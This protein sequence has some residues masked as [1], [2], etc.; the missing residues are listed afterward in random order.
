LWEK[1]GGFDCELPGT[2][3]IRELGE[4]IFKSKRMSRKLETDLCK[5][6]TKTN[7]EKFENFLAQERHYNNWRC[8]FAFKKKKR[9]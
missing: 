4:D 1:I 6:I 3:G 7:V 9:G 5:K 2:S 8:H